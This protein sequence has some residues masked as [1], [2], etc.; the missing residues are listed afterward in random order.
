MIAEKLSD[1]I[2][3]P[4]CPGPQYRAKILITKGRIKKMQKSYFP[5]TELVIYI[6][7]RLLS[8]FAR[9]EFS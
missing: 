9:S 5:N 8:N 4:C 7:Q 6:T 3:N 1:K 2:G